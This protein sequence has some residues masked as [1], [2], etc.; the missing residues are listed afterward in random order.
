LFSLTKK[1]CTALLALL[2]M[3]VAIPRTTF[4][5]LAA[6]EL[7][8]YYPAK[9][10]SFNAKALRPLI[11]EFNKAQPDVLVNVVFAGDYP[12]IY[13]A[14]EGDTNKPDLAVM[15]AT[16][17]YSLIDKD[18]IVP[19]NDVLGDQAAVDAYTKDFFP[20]FLLNAQAFGKLWGAPFQ[21]STQV[22]YY[23]KDLF[24]VAGLNADKA[25][26]TQ[27]ELLDAAKKLTKTDG[28]QWGIEI[29]SAGFP[30]WFF[31]GFAISNGQ[32]IVGEESNK[33]HFNDAPVVSALEF[34][35]AL[36]G[37]EAVMPK[38]QLAF[39]DVVTDFNSGKAAMIY[40]TSGSLTGILRATEGKFEVGVGFLPKG[41]AGYGAPVGGSNLVIFKSTSSEKQK[42]AW[43]LI[44]YLT[45]AETQ[46]QWTVA[47]GY[48]AASE[49]AW[50]T[51]T[52]KKLVSEKPLYT[53][54]KDQ[55]QY[56]GKEFSVHQNADIQAIFNKAFFAVTAGE[57]S[58]KEALD[59]AQKDADAILAKYEDAPAK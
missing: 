26:E 25:P 15:L 27:A 40:H 55:L 10:D 31:Q 14:L 33:V 20:A 1:L 38:G 45:S 42:A 50:E 43:Q 13:K 52:L 48:V 53:V 8:F 17:I 36:S 5:V 18:Q 21:R 3:A 24:K 39:G 44:D 11:D 34:V 51:D 56:A 54:A 4:T 46:A 28:S 30:Y 2:L 6:I 57:K 49:S 16:D 41:S 7:N 58:A 22:L 19:L 59:Q 47:T 12:D 9:P 29:P 35:A 32:N 37:K 23:N